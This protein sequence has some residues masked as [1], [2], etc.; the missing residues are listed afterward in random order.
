MMPVTVVLV[1]SILLQCTAAGLAL[2]LIRITGR[3]P[4][5]ILIAAAI[6]LMAI[7][8]SI[9]MYRLA[10]GN[11]VLLPDPAAECVALATSALMVLGLAWISPLFHA[12]KDSEEKLEQW[13]RTLE[14]KVEERTQQLV[15]AQT[16]V[17]RQ[18]R[19]ASVGQLAAGV[20]H[21]INNPLG[22]ILTFA[23][24][25]V[26]R[27]PSDSP[28][29][30]DLEEIVRQSVRCRGIV[31]DLLEFSRQREPHMA[32]ANVNDVVSR[33]LALIERQALFHDIAV[34]RRWA[35][36]MPLAT[37]DG[38]QM[39]QVF[40]NI[41]LNAADAMGK[42]GDLTIETGHDAGR[43]Y[44]F[45]RIIDTGCGIPEEQREAIFDP[46]FTAKEPGEGT[47][48]GLAVA[49]RIVQGHGGRIEVQSEVGSGTCFTVLLPVDEAVSSDSNPGPDPPRGDPL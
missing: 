35:P 46:F 22:A 37:M 19:L 20:A 25:L 36:D 13:A 10:S 21:E 6:L 12:I 5:W 29:R 28:H 32:A 26:E 17:A 23:S 38:S 24:L 1:A 8:R 7:R 34:T 39:Q 40:T 15:K 42:R 33:A 18:Q 4:A 45:V 3:W 48:L 49:Y 31:T 14:Q 44:V 9:T 41:I 16:E 11:E 43:G 30:E 47:G 27:L 2:R